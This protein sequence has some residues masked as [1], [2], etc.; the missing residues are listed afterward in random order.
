M[1]VKFELCSGKQKWCSHWRIA[2]HSSGMEMEHG[3]VRAIRRPF[4]PFERFADLAQALSLHP[5]SQEPSLQAL[6]A[7][8]DGGAVGSTTELP[9][10]EVARLWQQLRD[11]ASTGSRQQLS[12]M[13]SLA[14]QLLTRLP[15]GCEVALTC[16]SLSDA[17]DAWQWFK[18]GT[19]LAA[20][21][22]IP[23]DSGTA[24]AAGVSSG[25][26]AGSGSCRV[27]QQLGQAALQCMLRL[28]HL[29]FVPS[30]S[31]QLHHQPLA[32]REFRAVMKVR[33]ALKMQLSCN[34]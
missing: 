15:K 21:L 26:A 20:H 8:A 2:E 10:G 34:H 25:G 28:C 13:S 19:F 17:A 16:H 11:P 14:Q 1:L 32:G 29:W 4:F 5:D 27:P 3:G 22:L 24:A 6:A 7:W 31:H 23:D 18:L 12:R 9:L 30:P 33:K